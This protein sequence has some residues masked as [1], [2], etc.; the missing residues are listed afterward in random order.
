MSEQA[1]VKYNEYKT[2]VRATRARENE[3]R[4]QIPATE[5]FFYSLAWQLA[6]W[7]RLFE[8]EYGE[9]PT[10]SDCHQS[11][12]WT[13]LNEKARFYKKLLS[14]SKESRATTAPVR[15][16]ASDAQPQPPRRAQ[17]AKEPPQRVANKERS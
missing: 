17:R 5:P 1:E 12:T 2:K 13:A 8:E 6:A 7:S 4:A 3:R 11:S 15:V 14:S 16:D 10:E 9:P